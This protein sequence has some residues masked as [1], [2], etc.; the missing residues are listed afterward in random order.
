[1]STKLPAYETSMPECI[2]LDEVVAARKHGTASW[3]L[4]LSGVEIRDIEWDNAAI[5][6]DDDGEA[7]GIPFVIS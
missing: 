6:Y 2:D 5:A 3:A 7:Y 1:M 4:F